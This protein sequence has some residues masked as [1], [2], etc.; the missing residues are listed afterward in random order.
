MLASFPAFARTMLMPNAPISEVVL[1]GP[2]GE[3]L[4]R[5]TPGVCGGE[6]CSRD[7]RIMVWL[8]VSFMRQGVTDAEILSNYPTLTAQDLDAARAYYR[9]HSDEIDEAIAANEKDDDEDA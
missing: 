7:S 9:Q 6:A 3:P 1:S 4:V 8:L 5:K 2:N